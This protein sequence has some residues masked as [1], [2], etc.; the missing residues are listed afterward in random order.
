MK[1]NLFVSIAT[2][3]ILVAAFV[4]ATIGQAAAELS[5]RYVK[6]GVLVPKTGKGATWG[7]AAEVGTQLAT[8]EINAAGGIGGVKIKLVFYDYEAKESHGITFINKLAEADKVLA[9]SGPCFSSVVEVV[10]PLLNDLKIPVISYC[11][12]KPGLGT[13]SDW[14]FRNSIT[15][16]KQ[17]PPTVAAWAAEYNPKTVVII[18]DLED[19]VSKAE[20]AD[21]FPKL[22]ADSGI[23]V[24]KT[25]TYRTKDT[26]YSAQITEAK[27]LNPDGIALGSCYQQA[28]AIVKEARKQGLDAPVVG[29]A[30]TGAPEFIT[31]GGKAT[32]GSYVSTAAWMD[33]PS[34]LVQTFVKAIKARNGDKPFPYSA[35]RAY[36]NMYILKMIMEAE[37]V[38]N[39]A[40]DL[41]AD[42]LKIKQGWAKLK[43]YPG[44]SGLTSM[45]DAGDGTDSGVRVLK[46]VDGLYVDAS[47]TN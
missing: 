26:D 25:L 44:V 20:G 29:G 23:E 39:K 2:T 10:F 31:I 28:A 11:S 4:T 19:A 16:D 45:N 37:G 17:L 35:P 42:R 34:D 24:L 36:D 30:C 46:V 9:V 38:T 12:A 40:E 15:S 3:A 8:D 1:R 7:D 43:D 33:D 5:G 27:A 22:F 14:G 18:H 32:E 41:E 13:L 6:I 47:A 21:V